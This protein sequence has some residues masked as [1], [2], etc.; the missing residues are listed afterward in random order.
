MERIALISYIHGNMPALEAVLDDIAR[1]G[2][3]RILCLGTMEDRGLRGADVVDRVRACCEAVVRACWEDGLAAADID[4]PLARW[5][6]SRLGSDRLACLATL[7]FSLDTVLSGRHICLPH[8]SPQSVNAHVFPDAPE[9][10]LLAMFENSDLTGDWP[11]PDI[12]IYGDTHVPAWRPFGS[13]VLLNVGSVS[14]PLDG[15]CDATYAIIEGHAG[16]A[17]AALGHTI[18]RVPYDVERA[19]RDASEA[20]L[21]NWEVYATDLRTGQFTG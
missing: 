14:S 18:V 15:Q 16:P 12:V 3:T 17:V 8:A 10:R 21:P 5:H 13:R 2:M 11:L 20:R 6:L 19:I 7:P 1:R 4:H 9:E